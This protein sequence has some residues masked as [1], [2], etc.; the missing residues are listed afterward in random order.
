MRERAPSSA[1]FGRPA[2]SPCRSIIPPPSRTVRHL[3]VATPAKQ[4]STP[5]AETRDQRA[6]FAPQS[7]GQRATSG[8]PSRGQRA[9]VSRTM[10]DVVRRGAHVMH[11][12]E[13]RLGRRWRGC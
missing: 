5:P 1:H 8:C 11:E 13:R 4:R 7:C 3:I 10:R 6:C 9:M 12:E 2:T